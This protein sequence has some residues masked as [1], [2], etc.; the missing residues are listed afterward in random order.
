MSSLNNRSFISHKKWLSKELHLPLKTTLFSNWLLS[1]CLMTT[2]WF[3]LLL[4][5]LLPGSW[6]AWDILARVQCCCVHYS[7]IQPSKLPYSSTSSDNLHHVKQ[8]YRYRCCCT[9]PTTLPPN[10]SNTFVLKPPA[11]QCSQ[12]VDS[13][14]ILRPNFGRIFPEKAQK[15]AEFLKWYVSFYFFHIKVLKTWN[16]HRFLF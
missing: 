11:A 12:L 2:S 6:Y 1:I 15:G 10:A 7:Y 3:T 4:G 8:Q 5:D 14:A 13:S 9:I 16:F